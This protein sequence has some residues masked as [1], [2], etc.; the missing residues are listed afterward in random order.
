[1]LS[2]IFQIINEQIQE[3]LEA[4]SIK[5]KKIKMVLGPNGI[6]ARDTAIRI[7]LLR[8]G[9]NTEHK[10][11]MRESPSDK[12]F[13]AFTFFIL[14][15]THSYTQSLELTEIICDHFD[16]KP[17]LQINIKEH[18]FEV[19][20]STLDVTIEELNQFWLVQRQPHRPI[21]FYQA[22]ISEI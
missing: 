18:E 15:H 1:M 20:I 2:E 17:F 3:S 6:K 14:A 22:R 7:E 4:K 16:K 5:T 19:A 8:F 13:Y 10:N 21:L 11:F 9:L 12:S